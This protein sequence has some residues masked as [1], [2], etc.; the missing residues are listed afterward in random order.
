MMASAASCQA[1]QGNQAASGSKTLSCT[2]C[3]QRKVK[4]NKSYPCNHCQTFGIPCVSY[5]RRVRAPRSKVS[6]QAARD[7]ELLRRIRRLENLVSGAGGV[8]AEA[9]SPSVS[10][11]T[12]GRTPFIFNDA[13]DESAKP[14][15]RLDDQYASFIKQQGSGTRHLSGDFWKSLGYE[16]NDLRQLI[17]RPVENDED[18]FDDLTSNSPETKHSSPNF[19]LSDWDS[20]VDSEPPYPSD[21]HRSV[22]FHVYFANVDPLCRVLHRPTATAYLSGSAELLN[23]S[24]RRFKF[25]SLE[26]I[27]FAM[28]LAAVTS[29]SSQDC[30]THFSEEKDVLLT[31]YKRSTET[32]LAQAD[33][34]NS[35]EI[36]TLQAFTLYIVSI[37]FKLRLNF[38]RLI[39]ISYKL[40]YARQKKD[41]PGF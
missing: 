26:A 37:P 10:N 31:R 39:G 17:E 20:L 5:S 8:Q 18:D 12:T 3:R 21:C 4:C 34:L 19:I 9:P 23:H 16:F 11:A 36:I 35:M 41:N 1:T 14:G 40:V 6:G 15:A 28:Y 29:M 33:F 7:A 27:T 25:T 13:F 38:Q 2:S 22:L 32:A 30:M 24:T